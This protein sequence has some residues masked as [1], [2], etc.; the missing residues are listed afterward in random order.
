MKRLLITIM[1]LLASSAALFGQG[2]DEKL[3]EEIN[4]IKKSNNYIYA[5]ATLADKAEAISLAKEILIDN[6]NKWV[7]ETNKSKQPEAVIIRDIVENCNNISLMRGSMS[8]AFLYVEKKNIIPVN[9]ADNA[10]VVSRPTTEAKEQ[11][12]VV[13]NIEKIEPPLS[14][15]PVQK[16]VTTEQAPTQ[17]QVTTEQA[18]SQKKKK[19]KQDSPSSTPIVVEPK[20]EEIVAPA[21]PT[22]APTPAPQR[23]DPNDT[24]QQILDKI[25]SI[26]KYSEIGDYFKQLK[27]NNKLTYGKL[28]TLTSPEACYLLVFNKD[29][30]VVA[31]LD[32]GHQWNLKTQKA[33]NTSNYNGHG[34]IWFQFL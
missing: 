33:D 9:E 18:P 20:T 11:N 3:K 29:G 31:V 30:D 2:D 28:A 8:R 6:V 24:Q 16:E 34:I 5:E 1:L 4:K 26:A 23:V 7:S 14:E 15:V 12:L 17:G 10:V 25:V 13:S 22:P 19:T 21:E 27:Q 32:K